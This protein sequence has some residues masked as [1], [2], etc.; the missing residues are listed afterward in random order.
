MPN[1][2]AIHISK[3]HGTSIGANPGNPVLRH[4]YPC[5]SVANFSWRTRE[6][7]T[8]GHGFRTVSKITHAEIE[9]CRVCALVAIYSYF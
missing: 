4:V 6:R 7:A 3:S 8:D 2:A 9:S 5:P 1:V